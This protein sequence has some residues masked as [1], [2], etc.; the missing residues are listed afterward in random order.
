MISPG[1][2][3]GPYEVISALGSGGMG[4]VYRAR[5]T[6]LG[7]LVA[8]KVLPKDLSLDEERLARFE[9]EA[10][11]ASALNH[12]NI[13]VVH[14]I[15]ESESGPYIAMELV[16][17]TTVR[18]LLASGP[19]PLKRALSIAAQAAD[20]LANAHEA[21]IVHRDLKPE[22]LMVS[23]D[24][25]VKILD[26]GL[27]KL[28]EPVLEERSQMPTVTGGAPRTSAGTVLGTVGYM[29]PEQASGKPVDFRSDQFSFGA[30]L[31]EMLN[32]KRAFARATAAETMAAIIREEPEPLAT[33]AIV[34]ES[35]RWVTAR[36]LAKE[37]DE[38]YASTKDLARE[39]VGLLD[40]LSRGVLGGG[41][42]TTVSA[43]PRLPLPWTI[44]GLLLVLA[45]AFS[46]GRLGRTGPP[47][48]PAE[49]R[50]LRFSLPAPP[51][52]TVPHL[53][54][55]P[56]LVVS[57][58]GKNLLIHT[59]TEGQERLYV[60]S[61]D[62]TETRLLD[63]AVG[64]VFPFFSPDGRFVAFSAEGKLKKISIAGGPAETICEAQPQGNGS[65]SAQ[66]DVLFAQAAPVPGIYRVPAGGGKPERVTRPEEER[67]DGL[68]LWPHFLPGGRSFLYVALTFVSSGGGAVAHE[69]RVGSLDGRRA[70][71]L[72]SV[73]TRAEYAAGFLLTVREGRLLAQRF[74]V[75]EGRLTGTPQQVSSGVHHVYGPAYAGFSASEEVLIHQSREADVRLAWFDRG[76][77]ETSEL[78]IRAPVVGIRI[79]PDGQRVAL[80]VQDRRWGTADIWLYDLARGAPIRLQS[81]ATDESRPVW[82]PDGRRIAYRSDRT[83]P[84]DVYAIDLA[85]PG[86]E[87]VLFNTP[88]VE[89]PLDVSPD[90]RWLAFERESRTTGQDVWLHPLSG[91][92]E[93]RSF[94]Q[95]PFQETDLQFSGDGRWVAYVS[96]ESGRPEV[97]V[98]PFQ[99]PG[100]KVRLSTSSGRR[101]RWRR[102]G[103]ELYW[104]APGGELMAATLSYSGGQIRIGTP[105][106]LFRL[107]TGIG[108]YDAA[109]TGERFLLATALSTAAPPPIEVVVNWTAAL[110]P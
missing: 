84:P 71:N 52:A 7:R 15:G 29:S 77:R 86:N 65:W 56:S 36:C 37:P 3:L 80:D 95:T 32:G 67:K 5:H 43:G 57:P 51:G 27:A 20:G 12:P 35:V 1:A 92:G 99:R 22:N 53:N 79:S 102:D 87:Q 48:P 89:Q 90:G 94:L 28:A 68:D 39:T 23:K 14:D 98:A 59:Y 25:F 10:R 70:R 104:V 88:D 100:E 101:P 82:F 73:E 9:Q 54:I 21:G 8:I 19:L 97:Y 75:E 83:G 17:G 11:A 40:R 58:D 63:G 30:I 109:P 2:R 46:I 50:V 47:K 44:A 64:G 41:Q 107:E 106:S 6:R 66:G 38:R 81:D 31:Y 42:E 16:A 96:D 74:D 72:A 108:D 4:E 78:S 45:G 85:V 91:E 103:R 69:L 55:G 76:G 13:I 105:I 49:P 62:G 33:N 60:R 34:P 24:S 93:S 61:L 26:F 110:K 18:E